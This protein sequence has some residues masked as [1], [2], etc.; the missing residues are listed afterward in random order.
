MTPTGLYKE[1]PQTLFQV[2]D[3]VCMSSYASLS[4]RGYPSGLHGGLRTGEKAAPNSLPD[5]SHPNSLHDPLWLGEHHREFSRG[6]SSSLHCF[7]DTAQHKHLESQELSPRCGG[8]LPIG[9]RCNHVGF[10]KRLRSK[11]VLKLMLLIIFIEA[12]LGPSDLFIIT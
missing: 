5:A 12:L 10:W 8:Q 9:A 11:K 6:G 2:M 3:S 4:P 1:A 7:Q